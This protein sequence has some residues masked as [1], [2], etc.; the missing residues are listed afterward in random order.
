MIIPKYNYKIEGN[1]VIIEFKQRN[2]NLH[3]GLIDLEELDLFL[4]YKY[5]WHV[6]WHVKTKSYYIRATEYLG[7]IDGKP[8][9]QLV[10]FHTYLMNPKEDEIIDH[11]NHN[12]LDNRRDNLRPI[13]YSNNL[14]NRNGLND[15]NITGVRN[16]SWAKSTNRYLVQFQVNGKNTCFGRF[17]KED[18]DKA[19]QLAD[20]LRKEIY[21]EYTD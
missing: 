13:N 16:V 4:N 6:A 20:K 9:Y 11:R 2:G 15:N 5:K 1:T 10:Y 17:K 8:K 19:K 7:L 12:T 21:G 14:K 3:Y 18:F